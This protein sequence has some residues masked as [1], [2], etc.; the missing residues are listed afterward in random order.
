MLKPSQLFLQSGSDTLYGLYKKLQR[1]EGDAAK[2]I[3]KYGNKYRE[4]A[5]EN[6]VTK[7]QFDTK[8][9]IDLDSGMTVELTSGEL[10]TLYATS[11]RKQG[12][13]HLLGGGFRLSGG[14][15]REVRNGKVEELKSFLCKLTEADLKKISDEL[16][17]N[18]KKFTETMQGYMSDEMAKDGN[19]VSM[20]LYDVALFKDQFYIPLDVDDSTRPTSIEKGKGNIKIINKGMTQSLN[21][22]AA[23]GVYISNFSDVFAKHAQDMSSYAAFTLPL[24]N[25]ERVLNS[26]ADGVR[27]KAIIGEDL[28]REIFD[29]LK[30]VNGGIKSEGVLT[31]RLFS[32]SKAAR[33][34]LNLRVIIQQ[35]TAIV[36]AMSEIDPKYFFGT[37]TKGMSDTMKRKLLEEMHD[38]TSTWIVKSMG[39][40]DLN[41]SKAISDQ[42]TD[43]GVSGNKLW[44]TIP[45]IINKGSFYLAEKADQIAWMSLYAACKR[46]AR[47]QGFT[48]E[49]LLKRAG[50]RFD[51]IV[52]K[53]QVYDS[54]FSRAKILRSQNWLNKLA[55]MFMAE[56]LT[57]ANM[58]M[59]AARLSSHGNSA[60]A[61]RITAS[62]ALSIVITNAFAAIIDALRDDD[63]DETYGE[64]YLEAIIRN[65]MNDF[66]PATYI[67][68]ARD[69][70][71]LAQGY[72]IERADMSLISDFIT[73]GT[74][75]IKAYKNGG[76][77]ADSWL[78]FA[79]SILN[80]TG[81]PFSSLYRDAKAIVN[82]V[83]RGKGRKIG[84]STKTNAALG[85]F[86]AFAGEIPGYAV[87][88]S[89][90]SK[91]DKLYYAMVNGD[92]KYVK[93]TK[94][95]YADDEDK[96]N[97]L[98]K[99]GLKENDFRIAEAAQA[100]MDGD[101]EKYLE[102][103][104]EVVK[105]GYD[106]KIVQGAI[107]AAEN[108]LN[109]EDENVDRAIDGMLAT[110]GDI[111][112]A[113]E[114]GDSKYLND[115]YEARVKKYS[116]GEGK[117]DN[118]K[119]QALSATKAMLTD[120]Y[121][122]IYEEADSAERRRIRSIL[123]KIK[124][125]IFTIHLRL[126][127][128]M[129]NRKREYHILPFFL[130]NRCRRARLCMILL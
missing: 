119:K 56:P 62:V 18:L 6:G 96:F 88:Y 116:S 33:V 64:K 86:D 76:E 1:A 7:K 113:L 9:R 59:D 53:T 52:N 50:E 31:S 111:I 103:I 66:D 123:L 55:S 100:H 26:S 89:P 124:I 97:Q 27:I 65:L 120:Y 70:I 129:N 2:F 16:E 105:D 39:G 127:T 125:N 93:I 49:Y 90:H 107:L 128:G 60:K 38:Y 43:L 117:K 87:V 54:V 12:R 19:R 58:M 5:K 23:N 25:L 115:Y 108:K 102:L 15:I 74:N 126:T 75:L 118:P 67:P 35:P 36:R 109:G 106:E 21:E 110:K 24:E 42:I 3:E 73:K 61:A 82:T 72:D 47:A 44:E 37:S 63:D 41:T 85:S 14:I 30:D 11:R 17:D 22:K 32:L 99:K 46:E 28:S 84:D 8:H 20:Q 94:E 10:M 51:E 114:K 130:Y 4:T 71:S 122:P 45:N 13:Q 98:L 29:F 48:G 79:G 57:T 80:V 112:S 40:I 95:E 81:I 78:K 83:F 69:V 104:S 121:K 68:Y 91:S 34:G 77:L 92:D 101:T